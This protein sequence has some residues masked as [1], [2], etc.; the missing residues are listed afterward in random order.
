LRLLAE[1]GERQRARRAVL[2]PEQQPLAEDVH[3]L[4][5]LGPCT[6]LDGLALLRETLAAAHVEVMLVPEAAEQAAT[7]AGNLRRVERQMLILG[8]GEAHRAQLWQPTGAAVLAA[9]AADAIEALGLVARA[10]LPQVDPRAEQGRE[11]AHQITEIDA[12]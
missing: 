9:A 11:L 12:L 10:D 7:P 4:D 1:F 5:E 8:Q 3:G 2:T 6:R